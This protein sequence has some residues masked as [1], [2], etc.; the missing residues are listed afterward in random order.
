M[1]KINRGSVYE[2]PTRPNKLFKLLDL[3]KSDNRSGHQQSI[4]VIYREVYLDITYHFD[5][6]RLIEYEFTKD[7]TKVYMNFDE[8]IDVFKNLEVDEETL[9]RLR[10]G[11][12]G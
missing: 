10:E 1:I 6:D 7:S 12:Y 9:I 8:F 2:D 5:G 3:V 4:I 11:I